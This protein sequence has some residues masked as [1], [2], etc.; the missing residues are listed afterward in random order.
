MH[1]L[2]LAIKLCP[3]EERKK[4]V[5]DPNP[6]QLSPKCNVI[7]AVDQAAACNNSYRCVWSVPLF[8]KLMV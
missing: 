6:K 4:T 3:T 8:T 1:L 5:I 2:P 7:S